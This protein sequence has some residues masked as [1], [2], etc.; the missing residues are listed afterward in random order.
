[1]TRTPSISREAFLRRLGRSGLL[2]AAEYEQAVAQLPDSPRAKVLARALV[3]DGR[4][5]RFQAEQLLAGRS[6]GFVVGPYRILDKIAEGASGRV[7]R[8]EHRLL[9]RAVAL[10]VL[11]PRHADSSSARRLFRREMQAAAL[12]VHPNIILAHDAGTVRG[13]PFLALEY[14]DGPDLFRL[15]QRTGPLPVAVACEVARQTAGALAYASSLGI[16]H[17]DVKPGNLLLALNPAAPD[18]PV[19]VKLGDFGLAR[20]VGPVDGL[21]PLEVPAGAILGTPDFIAPEQAR[22]ADSADVRADLYSLG[23]TLYF[24]LA[25]RVPFPGGGRLE[26]LVRHC[27]HEP[28]RLETLRPDVPRSL[29][30]IVHRLLAKS[31]DD[32]FP[33]PHDLAV[34]LTP[35]CSPI[36]PTALHYSSED[37]VPAPC[38]TEISDVVLPAARVRPKDGPGSTITSDPDRTFSQPGDSAA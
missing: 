28:E 25:G 14:V 35:W 29:A 23:C 24:L 26:K 16:V 36:D 31:P 11:G 4:L 19:R 9:R 7:Y 1:M 5:T 20:L 18:E 10:K 30:D 13:R 6:Q 22:D 17:R 3:A 27:S 38:P 32:R 21:E 15:V 8:A 34:A 37:S 33:R 12:L 2:S